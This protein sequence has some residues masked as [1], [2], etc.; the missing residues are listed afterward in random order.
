M[1]EDKVLLKEGNRFIPARQKSVNPLAS[2]K[3]VVPARHGKSRHHW[4]GLS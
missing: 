4:S 3:S 1:E 2:V